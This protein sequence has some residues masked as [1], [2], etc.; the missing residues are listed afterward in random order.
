MPPSEFFRQRQAE[1]ARGRSRR[2]APIMA[3]RLQTEHAEKV[4]RA[5][6]FA[7]FLRLLASFVIAVWLFRLALVLKYGTVGYSALFNPL[8]EIGPSGH[9]AAELLMPDRLTIMLV[10]LIEPLT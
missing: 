6:F 3:A 7:R 4:E 9:L 8:R 5:G 10:A 1:L 2:G